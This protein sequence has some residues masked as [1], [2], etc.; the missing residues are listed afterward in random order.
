VASVEISSSGSKGKDTDDSGRNG[1]TEAASRAGEEN[2]AD[3]SSQ[4]R[5]PSLL[6]RITNME[7]PVA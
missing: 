3:K 1:G 4:A 5:R 7:K 2:A 6:Q